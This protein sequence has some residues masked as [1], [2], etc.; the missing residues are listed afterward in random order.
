MQHDEVKKAF[1]VFLQ[2]FSGEATL[3]KTLDY[4]LQCS[5]EYKQVK[6]AEY[7]YTQTQSIAPALLYTMMQVYANTYMYEKAT[8]LF[9]DRHKGI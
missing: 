2:R 5:G 9:Y 8:Q 1:D 7:F 4:L 6:L 3:K